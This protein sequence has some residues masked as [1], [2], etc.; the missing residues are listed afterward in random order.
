MSILGNRVL[1]REDPKFLTVGGTYVDDLRDERLT[2]AA[3]V[4]YVRSTMA[5][6]RI[7]SIDTT[8]AAQ[9]PG[10]LG[11]F[12][13][14]DVGLAATPG[15]ILLN[16]AVVRP[17]LAS[18]KVRFVGEPLVAV[19][20]EERYQGE[21]A[22]ELV[23]VDYEPL[24]ALI[25]MEEAARDEHLLHEDAGTNVVMKLGDPLDESLFEGCEVVVTEKILNQRVAIAPLEV[26]SC[27]AAWD[28]ARLTVWISTQAPQGARDGIQA[29]LGLEPGQVHLISPDVGGGFGAKTGVAP[30]ELLTAWLARHLGRPMRWTEN[31]T[32]NMLAMGHGR[33]QLQTVTIGGRRDGT[34]EAYRLEI[35][36]D[37][38]AYCGMGGMLP[39]L[40]RMMAQGVYTIPKVESTSVSV[41][42]NTTPTVAYRGAGRPEASAAIERAM[43][44]FAAEIGMD[45]ADVRR[46]NFVAAERFPWSS[47]TGLTYDSGD[48]ERALDLALATVGYDDLRAEQS[49]R[50]ASGDRRALGI[51][52][53]VF[54]D[55]TAGI[56]GSEYG[57]VTLRHDGT[58]LVHTGSSPYG[59][60]HHTAWAMLVSDRTGLPLERIE[61]VHGDTDVVPRGGITG[62][63]RSAQK[64]GSAIAEASDALVVEARKLAA[65]LLEAS[66]EDV[67]LDTH[68]GHFH[69]AGAPGAKTI[70]WEDVA[71]EV[72]DGGPGLK[73]ES[74]FSGEGPT[75]PFGAYVA[76]VEVDLDTGSVDLQRIVTVDD[77]GTILNPLLAEGQVHGGLA[78][79]L[80]QGLF[81]EFVY[82]G[83]GTPRTSTFADYMIP[84]AADLPSFE[85]FLIETPSPNN[86]MGFKGIAES[87]TIGGPPAVQN[88]VVDALAHLG[89]RHIDMPLTPERV[90]R[91]VGSVPGHGGN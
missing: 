75:F 84:T 43:D 65:D 78:Q 44:L 19:V 81:E 1:R 6:A 79:G 48:Y 55:R 14:D 5:H 82:D 88:A 30:E 17:P 23:F 32:E 73:C 7:L 50:R 72:A 63:S 34:V 69:V 25:D 29:L 18:G 74:D 21:D 86:P 64:A 85:S 35:V 57:A 77:A 47:P 70:A 90:W 62:G 53:S 49:R 15:L 9:A 37:A 45:P 28:G 51:G 68:A 52:I 67:V 39:F 24:P 2:G 54:I 38:G 56:K 4:T 36:A 66:P 10:V 11:V 26:R 22:A 60:G 61:V 13:A 41:V 42:T 71:A 12:T 31:R 91:A 58:I 3:Y 89:V 80:A 27:A 16:Q 46:K 33:G 59:Q 40:T 20:T 83:D 87:G 8:E 76:V